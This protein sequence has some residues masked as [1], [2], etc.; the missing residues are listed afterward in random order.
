MPGFAWTELY[1]M[2]IDLR[3]F[4]FKCVINKVKVANTHIEEQNK[5]I[6]ATKG[7]MP[8]KK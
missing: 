3:K 4:Y 8:R 6:Q 2:P 7:S 1:S 5:K